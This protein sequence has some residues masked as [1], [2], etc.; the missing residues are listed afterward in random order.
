M[1]KTDQFSFRLKPSQVDKGGIGIFALHDIAPDTWL[2]IE[3]RG[4]AVGA[5]YQES[6]IPKELL[7]YCVANPDGTWNGPRQFNH[8][9]LSWFLNHS[10]EPNARYRDDGCYSIK[11]IKAGDEITIDYNSLGEPESVKEDYY[12]KK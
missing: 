5:D 10:F 11:E 8:M 12:R 1:Q 6:D 4:Q 9:E 3:P 2:A 7:V